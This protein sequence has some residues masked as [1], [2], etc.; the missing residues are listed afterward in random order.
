M[1]LF[2]LQSLSVTMATGTAGNDVSKAIS[3]LTIPKENEEPV[4][5]FNKKKKAEIPA[6]PETKTTADASVNEQVSKN[7]KPKDEETKPDNTVT[8]FKEN[9]N[10]PDNA[11][12]TAESDVKTSTCCRISHN[13]WGKEGFRN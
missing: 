10:I 8:E 7:E 11:Q 1:G 6:D 4:I 9:N 2:N 3:E 5:S 13:E 12:T